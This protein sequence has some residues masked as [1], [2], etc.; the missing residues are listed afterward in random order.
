VNPTLKIEK[1]KGKKYI[2]RFN[3]TRVRAN[4]RSKVD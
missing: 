3:Q 1:K 4:F 2:Y